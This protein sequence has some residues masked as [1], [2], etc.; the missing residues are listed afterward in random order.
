MLLAAAATV[1]ALTINPY[2]DSTVTSLP[3]GT[4]TEIE[5]AFQYA[6]QQIENDFSDPITI[7]ITVV[8]TSGT[9]ILGQS[10][11][12]LIG[13]YTYSQIKSALT[14]DAKSSDDATAVANLPASD[15]TT[16]GEWWVPTAEAKALGLIGASGTATDGTFT[17]GTGFNYSYDQ[18]NRAVT[19][20]YDFIGVAEHEITEI[21]GRNEGLGLSGTSV[22]LSYLPYD[23]FRYVAT[24]TQSL[25]KTGTG[26]YFSIDGG[27]TNLKNFNNPGNGGDLQDWASGQG[28]D[29]FNAFSNSGVENNITAVDIRA[30]DVIGYDLPEPSTW[31]MLATGGGTLAT[32]RYRKRRRRS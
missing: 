13:T 10:N 18:N 22:P 4:V 31:A 7:N 20:D 12:N 5:T 11:T 27:V 8:A 28:P 21:M 14:A 6:A 15:P 29:S 32:V 24:G 2:Y 1:H 3:S 23:L 26:V 16:G 25:T 19:G 9:S 30:M 17:F